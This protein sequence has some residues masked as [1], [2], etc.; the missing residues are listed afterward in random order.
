MV[1]GCAVLASAPS[2]LRRC[3]VVPLP[4][5]LLLVQVARSTVWLGVL[6]RQQLQAASKT[7]PVCVCVN[8]CSQA[9]RQAVAAWQDQTSRA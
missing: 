4:L 6:S 7:L 2:S 9:G 1:A 3:V 5:L 8:V